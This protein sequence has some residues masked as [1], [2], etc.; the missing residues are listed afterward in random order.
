MHAKH[1]EERGCHIRKKC[2]QITADTP[3]E[4]SAEVRKRD[5]NCDRRMR[6]LALDLTIGY[7]GYK[8]Y[9]ELLQVR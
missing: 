2:I 6:Q 7:S 3:E 4:K 5:L 1:L 9:L 8:A